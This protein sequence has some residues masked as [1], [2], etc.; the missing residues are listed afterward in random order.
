MTVI[1]LFL[2]VESVGNYTMFNAFLTVN[3]L[4]QNKPYRTAATP[5]NKPYRTA[6]LL[7]GKVYR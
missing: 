7:C 5:S 1:S 3:L 4:I 2:K 6:T